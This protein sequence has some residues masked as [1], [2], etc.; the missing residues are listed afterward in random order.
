MPADHHQHNTCYCLLLHGMMAQ[1]SNFGCISPWQ[2]NEIV[3][4]IE[5]F[6][7]WPDLNFWTFNYGAHEGCH[8]WL[9]SSSSSSSSSSVI[10]QTT[11][12]KLLPKWFLHIVRSTAS[13]FNWHY[14]LLSLRLSSR[15]LSLLPHLLVNSIWP[16][17]FPS[18]TCCRRQ[19][20]YK[21]WPIQLAFHF[22]ISCRI[23]LCSLTLSN[24]SSFLTGSVKLI[25]SIILQ[26]H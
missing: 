25:S 24:A 19:F 23:F 11:G 26:H 20:L 3:N 7:R 2:M 1:I 13:S 14:P 18:I 4:L 21:I 22:I 10:C 6:E 17:I 8:L 15:F 5:R 16:F 12:P 9:P